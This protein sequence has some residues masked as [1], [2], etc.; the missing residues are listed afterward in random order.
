MAE[1][2]ITLEIITPEQIAHSLK[3]DSA[4]VPT[5]TGYI[6]IWPNHAPLITSLATGVMWYRDDHGEKARKPR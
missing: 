1:G 5:P 2:A 3:V 4:V 6:A